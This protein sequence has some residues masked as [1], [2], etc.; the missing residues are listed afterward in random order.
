VLVDLGSGV[1]M[2]HLSLA[3]I[4]QVQPNWRPPMSLAEKTKTALNESRMLMLGAQ[5]FLGFQFQAPF[6]NAFETL[7][8]HEKTIEVGVLC[9]MVVVIGLLIAPSARH[10][11]VERGEA[12][13]AINRFITKM[14]LV[15]LLPF[16]VALAF[17]L[18]IAGTR[19]AGLWLGILF[20]LAGFCIALGF[21]YGPLAVRHNERDSVMEDEKTSTAAKINYALTEARVVLPGAQALLGFQLAIVLTTGFAELPATLKGTH[22]VAIALIVLAIVLLM[23]PAAYHRIVYDGAEAPE[24]YR[25][26]SRYL[27]AATVFL[28]LGLSADIRVVVSKITTSDTLAT[29]LAVV[30]VALLLGLW[31]LW[32]WWVRRAHF[33]SSPVR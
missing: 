7:S 23:T 22:A 17:D 12:T 11:I 4:P 27:L 30:S 13:A 1:A 8:A 32:P 31:H 14:A 26:T 2:E 24:F 33:I 15:T 19:V 21:W 20:G 6:Q 9:I 16:G 25:I 3:T 18:Y 29:T 5:I 10:R 28:A